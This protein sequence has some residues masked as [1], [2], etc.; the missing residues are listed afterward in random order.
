MAEIILR[1]EEGEQIVLNTTPN[2]EINVE[3]SLTG[4]PGSVWRSG[5]DDPD[6]DLGINGD[7]YFNTLTGDVFFKGAGAYSQIA[8]IKGSEGDQGAS[9]PQGPSGDPGATWNTGSG[10]PSNALGVDGD[11]YFRTDT[12][13]VYLK[14]SGT[15]SVVAD[16]TGPTGATGA[17]GVVQSIVAGSNVTVDDT[18]PANPIIS[19][20]SGSG[21]VT[22][23]ASST[24]NAIVRFD[25][26]TGKL[27]QDYSSLPVTITDNGVLQLR[28]GDIQMITPGNSARFMAADRTTNGDGD[29]TYVLGGKAKGSG[30]AGGTAAL[31]GGGVDVS[32]YGGG[33]LVLGGTGKGGYIG[34]SVELGGGNNTDVGGIGGSVSIYSG[35]GNSIANDGVIAI[36]G[37]TRVLKR[38]NSA[39]GVQFD[40]SGTTAIRTVTFP[41]ATTTLVGTDTTQT[42]TNKTLSSPSVT[43]YTG[44]QT[45][46]TTISGVTYNGNKS[47]TLTTSTD[48]TGT[49]SPGMRIRTTRSVAAPTQCTSLNG[50]SQYW[51]KSSP[52]KLTFTDD[53]VVSA[54]I[55]LAAYQNETIVSRADGNNGWQLSVNSSGQVI[56]AGYAGAAGGNFSQ[57]ISYQSLPLNKWVHVA[58]QLDMSTFTATTATSYVMIDGIDIPCSV[59]RGGT[60]P[61]ALVQGGDLNV[62]RLAGFATQ[63]FNG[64]IAQVAIFNAK[65]TQATMRGYISQGLS[66]S[67]TSLASAYSF[68]GAATDLN[69]T[70][71]NDLTASG[72]ATA[73]NADSPFGTQAGGSISST[74][75]YGVVAAVDSSTVTVQVPEGCTIPTS[76]GVSSIRYSSE[77][78]PYAFPSSKYRWT[79]ETIIISRQSG[80]GTADV[81]QNLGH[82]LY[83]PIGSWELGYNSL[84]VSLTGGATSFNRAALTIS[85]SNT[86]R[87]ARWTSLGPVSSVASTEQA[88]YVSKS[89]PITVTT[90]AD[91]FLNII[92]GVSSSTVYIG[93]STTG[94]MGYG[95]IRAENT[96][97]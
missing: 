72:S 16:L 81:A 30:T 45:N 88:G 36:S 26:A 97:I 78:F 3:G 90:A 33:A 61:T 76:G 68:N 47:Y 79:L 66:G 34:G 5:S 19:T 41:D 21:D 93:D 64:K 13:E 55:K 32:G 6:N 18:D 91:Y 63:P 31:I 80:S 60:N 20:G 10:A 27:V 35:Q 23:P 15:Y 96:Y 67:E 1:S 57:V 85:T 70:T 39:H 52:N 28:D 17:P 56:L 83:L 44:W 29:G 4:P 40:V 54:W 71:P 59:S 7:Y 58:A 2:V 42:L 82:K 22:G 65:V 37:I 50:S 49:L 25:G 24:D 48:Q 8:N 84:I 11:L 43:G 38:N 69:T 51:S 14:T 89:S 86:G 9:G 53:F 73:T 74:L 95:F 62:G 75:D 92:A 46:S 87:D 77:R 94:S 12:G